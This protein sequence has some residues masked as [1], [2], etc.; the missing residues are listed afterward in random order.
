MC[1]VDSNNRF[2]IAV[3]TDVHGN[4]PALEAVL[5]EVQTRQCDLVYHTGDS[6]AIG[7]FPSECLALLLRKPNVRMIMGNHERYLVNGIPEPRPDYISDGELAHQEWVKDQLSEQQMA[8]LRLLPYTITH[9]FCG[10]RAAF[11]HS[12]LDSNGYDFTNI[13]AGSAEELDRYFSFLAADIVF[14]GHLHRPSRTKGEKDYCNPGA[15]GCSRDS[16]ARFAL[17]HLQN[18]E[19]RV[20]RVDIEYDVGRVLTELE[21]R[22]VPDW[23]FIAKT[24]YG[25]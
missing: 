24:F 12:C 8:R 22:D 2:T 13:E 19:Y 10:V 7:P 11:I 6:I 4:L 23:E 25:A 21:R 16:R 18:G 3:L 9:E 1:S 15:A 5:E 14:F 20:E 17:L